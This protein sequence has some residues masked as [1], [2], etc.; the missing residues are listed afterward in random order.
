MYGRPE[1]EPYKV[2]T[3]REN[4]SRVYTD[5]YDVTKANIYLGSDK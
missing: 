5:P 4:N 1:T 2:T 3:F